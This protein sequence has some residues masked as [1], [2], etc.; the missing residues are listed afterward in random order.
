MIAFACGGSCENCR[1]CHT[2]SQHNYS[3][4]R[5]QVTQVPYF[6]QSAISNVKIPK[7]N[8]T[9][10]EWAWRWFSMIQPF[11]DCGLESLKA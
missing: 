1:N 10:V 9:P 11:L 3:T 4:F 8:N 7:D 5:D 6:C 2:Q